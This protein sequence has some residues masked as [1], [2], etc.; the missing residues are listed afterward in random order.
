MKYIRDTLSEKVS[1]LQNV[2]LA[3]VLVHVSWALSKAVD[4]PGSFESRTSGE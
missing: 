2:P 1:S 3:L 4:F